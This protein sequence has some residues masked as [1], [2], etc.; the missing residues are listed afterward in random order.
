LYNISP[1]YIL[2]EFAEIAIE[3]VAEN[4]RSQE[5]KFDFPSTPDQMKP[6]VFQGHRH[7]RQ[8]LLLSVLSGIPIK[9]EKI[10]S[11]QSA[12]GLKGNISTLFQ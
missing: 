2:N 9:I 7:F 8:R 6:L 12:P 1:I 11:E 3:A 10:R 4:R 5:K